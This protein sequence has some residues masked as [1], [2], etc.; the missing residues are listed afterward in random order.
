MTEFV[1]KFMLACYVTSFCQSMFVN[2]TVLLK[3]DLSF[4]APLSNHL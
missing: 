3:A 4:I 2:K 1:A